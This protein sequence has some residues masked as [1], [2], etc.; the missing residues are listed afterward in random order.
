MKQP[1]FFKNMNLK[2]LIKKAQDFTI[3]QLEK[4]SPKKLIKE[5]LKLQEEVYIDELTSLFN[6]KW[7][8]K[9]KD[10]LIKQYN[11]LIL[12]D[13]DHFKKIN[14]TYGHQKGDEIL[15]KVADSLISIKDSFVFVRWGGEEIII[16][17]NF[18][19]E[20]ELKDILE[21]FR[22]VIEDN[23]KINKKKVTI[24]LGAS[25]L[26]DFDSSFF[27]ADCALYIS[28]D[29]GRNRW[30]IY[31]EGMKCPAHIEKE[32]GEIVKNENPCLDEKLSPLKRD[33][34][35]TKASLKERFSKNDNVVFLRSALCRIMDPFQSA[36][37]V[38]AG[39]KGK[40]VGLGNYLHIQL[41]DKVVFVNEF[42][43]IKIVKESELEQMQE[44]IQAGEIVKESNLLQVF[45]FK[46]EKQKE[47]PI[48]KLVNEYKERL[49]WKSKDYEEM[50]KFIE[51]KK[52]PLV[53][54]L[55]VDGELV[56]IHF[57]EDQTKTYTKGGI[58][59]TDLPVTDEVT[60]I[61]KKRK[62][63]DVIFF[64]ELYATDEKGN[65]ISYLKG[66]SILQKPKNEKEEKRIRLIIFD[67]YS[68]DK[69]K[70]EGSYWQKFT[71]I[72]NLFE[73][74]KYVKPAATKKG[75]IKEFNTFWD[76]VQKGKYEGIVIR[77]NDT[78]KV[79]PILTFDLAVIGIEVSDTHPNWMGALILAFM[80]KKRNFRQAG[81]VGTGFKEKERAEWLKWAKQNKV[82]GPKIKNVIWIKPKRVVEI[83]A[84]EANKREAKVY[85]FEKNKYVQLNN[86]LSGIM[87][88]PSFVRIRGDKSINVND[89]R[90][91]QIPGW[92]TKKSKLM[93]VF[94]TY[95]NTNKYTLN[96][97]RDGNYEIYKDDKIFTKGKY[98][99]KLTE[100]YSNLEWNILKANLYNDLVS[101]YRKVFEN[102]RIAIDFDGVIVSTN[103]FP[104]IGKIKEGAKE[105]LKRL[106]DDGWTII[107]YS[108][109]INS[110]NDIEKQIVE[111]KDCLIKNNILYDYISIGEKPIANI[112][113]DDRAIRFKD[114]KS[115]LEMVDKIEKKAN[116]QRVII[117]EDPI[118]N[119]ETLIEQQDNTESELTEKNT[120]IILTLSQLKKAFSDWPFDLDIKE[121]LR[122]EQAK[123]KLDEFL[124]SFNPIGKLDK[125]FSELGISNGISV[126]DEVFSDESPFRIVRHI[127]I[128]VERNSYPFTILEYTFP[129]SE[130][131]TGYY[132][133]SSTDFD[134]FSNWLLKY[135]PK[136]RIASLNRNA[137]ILYIVKLPYLDKLS[138]TKAK[139][140]DEAFRNVFWKNPPT[141]NEIE[142][143][144]VYHE[145]R[146]N[147]ET[148]V[149]PF[150]EYKKKQEELKKI[151]EHLEET[152]E[153][154]QE[155]I[156]NVEKLIKDMKEEGKDTTFF[157][158]QL[159]RLKKQ[160]KKS[161]LSDPDNMMSFFSEPPRRDFDITIHSPDI[162]SP[163]TWHFP[164][165]ERPYT[166]LPVGRSD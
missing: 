133:K 83:K 89:L 75:R 56:G 93:P 82:N 70:V 14:D 42:D 66:E 149:I 3:E 30:T 129:V 35:Y 33:L 139:T 99:E 165:G 160:L 45:G 115:T 117:N 140:V 47:N 77:T 74:G 84:E 158:V 46:K 145:L 87:R 121:E 113:I 135:V 151:R 73:K 55:K 101:W 108:A 124:S 130:E 152:R 94:V 114:W 116:V 92:I 153:V 58:M 40:V 63:K 37:L 148:Y 34:L 109:R 79:K 41:N 57:C 17:G 8:E 142:N 105:A 96:F 19:N 68:I 24:S 102:K 107:I 20:K 53:V 85:K 25:K 59:R 62:Y 159:E 136:Q 127:N 88:K 18:E 112:Y 111:I 91:E 26:E 132:I 22:K 123:Q 78:I 7:L 97:W 138:Y 69:K 164:Y 143:R 54:S 10:K 72:Q 5:V 61:L 12:I 95:E 44:R 65:P 161:Y 36:L 80:D 29:R 103:N 128:Y 104:K 150:E 126:L 60:S 6:R 64:G 31:E 15:K 32:K 134:R 118:G 9:Y 120:H 4:M 39:T 67:V 28:K 122:G 110:V 81:K 49:H 147:L 144:V 163:E 23:V 27:N 119:R 11:W 146:E 1:S 13:I 76:L 157:E 43:T 71:L 2:F 98:D 162:T 51:E 21:E 156:N 90:L 38:E 125:I 131:G 154:T 155:Q 100:I 166:N 16:L 48:V 141:S 52:E 106:K 137:Q 50:K 86:M